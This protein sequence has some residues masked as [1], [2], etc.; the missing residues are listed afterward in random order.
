MI[1]LITLV[2]CSP[3]ESE[4]LVGDDIVG[5]SDSSSGESS[6]GES[7]SGDSS[8]GDSSSGDSSSGDS[9]SG[10][11][12][13]SDSST[14]D[15]S[16]SD[17]SS[18][19]ASTSDSSDT[20]PTDTTD[21]SSTGD[22]LDCV[23]NFD[24]PSATL[25][26]YQFGCHVDFDYPVDQCLAAAYGFCVDN[27]DPACG[28]DGDA[29]SGFPIEWSPDLV[30]VTCIESSPQ[31]GTFATL[32]AYQP[33]CDGASVEGVVGL[34]CRSAIHHHCGSLGFATGFGP[35]HHNSPNALWTCLDADHVELE[36]ATLAQLAQQQN[37][38]I[39]GTESMPCT[40]AAHRYCVALGHPSG[41]G[42]I[43]LVGNLAT[44]VCVK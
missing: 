24:V 39:T 14:S 3:S 22:A 33:A 11:S 16:T 43:E 35:N 27:L 19:D 21:D 25:A 31:A 23:V 40:A 32:A 1:L 5:T 30:S 8:S 36:V 41:Y 28:A 34:A 6:S 12:S 44:L 38:C 17:S 26:A 18:G 20:D 13:T 9:S 29:P 10:D 7:S 37:D 2:G 15:S 42:P 4:P